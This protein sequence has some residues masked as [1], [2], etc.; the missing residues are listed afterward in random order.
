MDRKEEVDQE[1]I[2]MANRRIIR[3]LHTVI[4]KAKIVDDID[5]EIIE[6]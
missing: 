6:G 4:H 1:C 3:M 2:Y 5:T